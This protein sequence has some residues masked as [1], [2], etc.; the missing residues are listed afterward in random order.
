MSYRAP[1]VVAPLGLGVGMDLPWRPDK[2]GF[3]QSNG[4]EVAP[5][6]RNF[7]RTAS[8]D[9]LQFDEELVAQ[10]ADHRAETLQRNERHLDLD[11]RYQ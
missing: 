3:R 10:L 7:L 6:V 1:D 5:K 11:V 2:I 4:G 9:R 8:R